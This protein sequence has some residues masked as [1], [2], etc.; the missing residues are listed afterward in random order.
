MK[1]K[2]DVLDVLKSGKITDDIMQTL[3]TEAKNMI[4]VEYGKA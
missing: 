4:E 3:E 1:H 2:A